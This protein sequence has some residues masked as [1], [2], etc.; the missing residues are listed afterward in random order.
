MAGTSSGQPHEEDSRWGW[1]GEKGVEN[2]DC[3]FRLR[4]EEARLS[5]AI[6]EGAFLDISNR[7]R[8]GQAVTNMRVRSGKA[9]AGLGPSKRISQ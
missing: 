6:G 7:R 2:V 5:V 1:I 9:R 3:L 8:F 4:V